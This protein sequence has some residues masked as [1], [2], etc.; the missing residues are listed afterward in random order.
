MEKDILSE[1]TEKQYQTLEKHSR[2][3]ATPILNGSYH[4]SCQSYINEKGKLAPWRIS[5]ESDGLLH[6]W[7]NIRISSCHNWGL[8]RVYTGLTRDEVFHYRFRLK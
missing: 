7:N 5:F 6:I 8:C 4:A 2:I 3:M 1:M